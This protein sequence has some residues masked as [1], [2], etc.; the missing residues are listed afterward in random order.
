MP[1]IVKKKIETRISNCISQHL[2]FV[3][4]CRASLSICF[5]CFRFGFPTQHL[6]IKHACL[7][8]RSIIRMYYDLVRILVV[9]RDTRFSLN[10][11]ITLG[12][13][14]VEGYFV[15]FYSKR[16]VLPSSS[17]NVRSVCLGIQIPRILITQIHYN[18]LH[19]ILQRKNYLYAVI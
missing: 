16:I 9:H 13:A 10:F 17:R 1:G 2:L 6:V 18:P 19:Y 15:D 11:E 4:F 7:A 12:V 8:N 5:G 3:R 14:I